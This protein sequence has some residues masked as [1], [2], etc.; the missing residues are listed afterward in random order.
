MKT[1]VYIDASNLFYGGKKSLG[2]SIDYKKLVTYLQN[3]YQVSKICFFG[4]VEI[5]KFPFDYLKNETVPIKELETYL[6]GLIADKGDVMTEAELKLLNRHLKRVR[7]YIKLDEFGYHLILK[8]VKTFYDEEGIPT[9]KAN[10][11][12]DMAFQI[13]KDEDSFD[14]LLVLSGDGD[15]LPVLKY[16]REKKKKILVLARSERTAREIKKFAG[17]ELLDFKYI[18]I[19]IEYT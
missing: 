7:F 17:G 18:R 1:F 10:C 14:R 9:R 5:H 15:F 16:M 19:Y 11:D 6:V 12:V 3:K 4:G 8:P 2:W 13:M